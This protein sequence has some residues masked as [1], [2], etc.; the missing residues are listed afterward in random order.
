MWSPQPR[1]SLAGDQ[2]SRPFSNQR[3]GEIDP[4]SNYPLFMS[5]SENFQ[6]P[7][8]LLWDDIFPPS[9]KS[10]EGPSMD[11]VAHTLKM[12]WN[13]NGR[14]CPNACSWIG[15]NSCIT[16]L[17]YINFCRKALQTNGCLEC[18]SLGGGG[19]G[20]VLDANYHPPP[21]PPTNCWLG[22]PWG[23]GGGALEGGFREGR[24]GGGGV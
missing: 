14:C 19:G 24:M 4:N 2:G 23:A 9:T 20:S 17:R 5:I 16:S 6:M 15:L 18:A 22:A 13:S 12:Q 10:L 21:P 7:V 8:P 11:G 3:S 1:P